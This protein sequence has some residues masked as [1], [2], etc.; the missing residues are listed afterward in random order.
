MRSKPPL[1]ANGQRLVG[2]IELFHR[3]APEILDEDVCVPHEAQQD[4]V[5]LSPLE[6]ERDAAL[7]AVEDQ[8]RRRNAVDARLAVPARV[9]AAGELLDLDHVRAEI[10]EQRATGRTGHDLRQLEHAHSDERTGVRN[11]GRAS[12]H[13]PRKAGLRFARNAA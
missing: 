1:S 3:A 2:E 7:V 13:R 8:I 5:T 9:V 6:V 4:L 10:G 11:R 12:A